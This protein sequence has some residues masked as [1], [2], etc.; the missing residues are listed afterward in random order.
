MFNYNERG[1]NLHQLEFKDVCPVCLAR[2]ECEKLLKRT[3]SKASQINDKVKSI[4]PLRLQA[5]GGPPSR[6]SGPIGDVEWVEGRG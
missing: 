3:Y 6:H 5:V 4:A 2:K 1:E